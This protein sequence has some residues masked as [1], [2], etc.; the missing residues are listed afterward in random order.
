MNCC[1]WHEGH[2]AEVHYDLLRISQ[3]KTESK[4][5]CEKVWCWRSPQLAF[6]IYWTN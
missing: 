4:S 5:S 1:W 2:V 6:R 3:P